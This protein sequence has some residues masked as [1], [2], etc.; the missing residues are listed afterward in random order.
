MQRIWKEAIVTLFKVG[1]LFRHLP[2]ETEENKDNWL[3]GLY[4]NPEPYECEAGVLDIR[5][6][7]TVI[8]LFNTPIWK[9]F[10]P[11]TIQINYCILLPMLFSDS[12]IIGFVS[13]FSKAQ[14]KTCP[15][16]KS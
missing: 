15:D 11:V 16:L 5:P 3:L 6:Q 4:L 8:S 1:P 9:E 12:E 10:E 13:E 2:K 7:R 14:L